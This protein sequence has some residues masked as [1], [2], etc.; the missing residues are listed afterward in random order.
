MTGQILSGAMHYFRI[1]P[2]QW[3]DRLIKLQAMGLDTVETYLAWNLHE[4]EPRK[5]DFAGPLDVA[6]FVR[7]AGSIGLRVIVRPGPY[8]CAE[9]E[10]GGLPAWLLADPDMAVRCCYEPYLAAVARYL[11]AVQAQ[12]APLQD[13]RGGPIIAVQI[14]N[15]YGAFGTDKAYLE[16]LRRALID[17][18]FDTLLFTA[19]QAND[20]ALF[21]GGLD[22]VWRTVTFARDSWQA[23]EKAAKYQ[24]D[25]AR[26]CSELWVGWFDH[27][28][29]KHHTRSDADRPLK[30]SLASDSS[31]NLYMFHGGTN[32]GFMNGANIDAGNG[33]FQPLVT[34]YDYDA[35]LDEA[36]EP[37]RKFHALRDVIAANFPLPPLDLPP[38][39]NRLELAPFDFTHQVRLLASLPAL[40]RPVADIVPR[41]MES[42]G[43][44]HGFILYRTR[45]T[46]PPGKATLRAQAVRDRAQVFVAGVEAGLLERDGPT[47]L[48]IEAPEGEFVIDIL[49]ENLGRVNYGPQVLDRKGLLG[50]VSLA[51]LQLFHWEM[52][53]L[54]LSDLSALDFV[55]QGTPAGPTFF[56]TAIEV[57][58]PA[59]TFLEIEGGRKGVAWI[60]GFNLGRYWDIGPQTSL[61]LPAPLLRAGANELIILELHPS[62]RRPPRAS[63]RPQR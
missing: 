48:E 34:S 55:G 30:N 13:T 58:E 41:P 1:R 45:V 12:L 36:G 25:A 19:D 14:E 24:P 2:E 4:P 10:M 59:D 20:E 29:G 57:P 6:A 28:G 52:R 7:L 44:S 9:W 3:R 15:E 51:G 61:Y 11:D 43:Q 47:A 53:P 42:L 5:F 16:W 40:S 62:S 56:R 17:R 8:I 38:P 21:H 35:P 46:H 37:T 23:F 39:A 60:N 26:F 50:W 31:A 22:G 63:F 27:W 32:F 49:V 18:G 54:P 33:A